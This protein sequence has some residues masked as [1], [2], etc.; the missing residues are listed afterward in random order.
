MHIPTEGYQV[1]WPGL[2]ERA[3]QAEAARLAA[4][5]APL[6]VGAVAAGEVTAV[7]K[8]STTSLTAVAA[9]LRVGSGTGIRVDL[10]TPKPTISADPERAAGE[11][12]VIAADGRQELRA[13]LN[14]NQV[15]YVVRTALATVGL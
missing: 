10:G 13:G 2:A 3:A 8:A 9:F 7:A 4:E 1:T 15:G 5:L 6:G 14:H 12:L 11:L